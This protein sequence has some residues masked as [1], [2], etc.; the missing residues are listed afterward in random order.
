MKI[1]YKYTFLYTVLSLI[2]FWLIIK[3]GTNVLNNKIW[4]C[5]ETFDTFEKY[6]QMLNPYP[7]DALIDMN[8]RN[9]PLY[10]HT[11]DLPL[12]YPFSC[13]NFCGPKSQCA[14]TREQCTSD[15]DCQGCNPGPTPLS[16]CETKDV[17]GAEE[18]GKYGAGLSYS[19]LT[20]GS[21]GGTFDEAY[22][23]SKNAVIYQTYRGVDRWENSFNTGL[24]L[25]NADREYNNGPTESELN[26]IP[27]YP[28]ERSVTGLFYQTTP[29][30]ANS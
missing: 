10:S 9:S 12:N 11:V 17:P 19:Y 1:N 29:P 27:K 30:A 24:K 25:Y 7:K 21:Y 23:G 5:K 22:P 13:K 18:A 14:I 16:N 20:S 15:V 28:L 8:D 3:Y 6:S 26:I 4:W 2:L